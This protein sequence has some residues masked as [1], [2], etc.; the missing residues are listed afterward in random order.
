MGRISHR[1]RIF[2]R[3]SPTELAP[4]LRFL[5][6]TRCLSRTSRSGPVLARQETMGFQG[7]R[8]D[9]S[10]HRTRKWVAGLFAI[11]AFATA[12]GG[13]AAQAFVLTDSPIQVGGVSVALVGQSCDRQIDPNWSYADILGLD[14]QIRITNSGPSGMTFDPSAT[15]LLA[16]GESR[17]PHRADGPNAIAAGES[18][19]FTVHFLERDANLACNV[20][21]ALTLGRAAMVG[22]ASVTLAPISFL[23]SNRDI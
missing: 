13:C 9:R 21:M 4:R 5:A 20:P 15:R 11:S 10:G 14:L 16:D 8:L 3:C 7:R 6:E 17:L 23:A 22:G 18:R 12:A 19:T 2:S 1:R